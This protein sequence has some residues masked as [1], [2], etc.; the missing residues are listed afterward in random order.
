MLKPKLQYFGHLRRRADSLK[1]TLMLG[2]I[3]GRRRRGWQKM[4]WLDGITNRMDMSLSKL[5]EIVK[6][7]ETWRAAVHGVAK[8]WAWLS[9]LD[10][11]T[12]H[13][14]S[15]IYPTGLSLPRE[16][17]SFPMVMVSNRKGV[18]SHVTKDSQSTGCSSHIFRIHC[19]IHILAWQSTAEV[20]RLGHFSLT[21]V[22]SYRQTFFLALPICW[23]FLRVVLPSVAPST[24]SSIFSALPASWSKPLPTSFPLFLSHEFPSIDSLHI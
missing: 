22:I 3:E 6:D 17:C 19:H 18:H 2:K 13:N 20:L 23:D 12:G 11:T 14:W 24:Q 4:R 8:T 10:I 16:W 15:S 5:R 21:W 9:G 1:K 7:R